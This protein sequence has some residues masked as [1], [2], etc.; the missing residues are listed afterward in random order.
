[1]ARLGCPRSPDRPALHYV[2]FS[3]P[4]F[5]SRRMSARSHHA[6]SAKGSLHSPLAIMAQAILAILLASAIAATSLAACQ[7]RRKP[8]P[9]FGAMDLGIPDDRKRTGCEQAT[10]I[11]VAL[12]A[13]IAELV[14]ASTRVLP[15]H[16]PDTRPKSLK[17]GS[18]RSA[19]LATRAAA[20]AGP[21]DIIEP[22][23]DFAR[24]VPGVDHTVELQNI[25]LK[26]PQLGTERRE[27]RAR[28]GTRLS[29][30]SATTPSSSSTP[31]RPSGATI[32]NSA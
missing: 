9:V 13:D 23:A 20:N 19:T 21:T 7:Q 14:L 18:K 2:L 5:T 1:M 32:P 6:A 12:F 3:L 28:K 10:Q 15:G 17:S 27:T 31:R 4:T 30:G 8:W 16:E 24:S 25:L 11:V 26:D 29:F 22:L